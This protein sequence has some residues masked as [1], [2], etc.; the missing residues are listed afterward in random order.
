MVVKPAVDRRRLVLISLMW[1]GALAGSWAVYQARRPTK[2]PIAKPGRAAVSAAVVAGAAGAVDQIPTHFR[3]NP[4]HTAQSPYVGPAL[5][6]VRWKRDLG[7]RITAQPVIG[8]DANI[9]I[10]THDGVLWTLNSEGIVVRKRNLGARIF[11]AALVA[12]DGTLYVGTDGRGFFGLDARSNTRF[13]L[14]NG[15]LAGADADT[16]PTLARDGS[17]R[18]AAGD[19][20]YSINRDGEVLWT[21]RADDKIFTSPTLDDNG[22][23]YI[24][25]QDEHVYAVDSDGKLLFRFRTG[26]DIDA[27]PVLGEDGTIYVG[28][29]DQNVYAISQA[30]VQRW[31]TKLDGY[32]RGALALG[33][34]ASLLATHW[35]QNSALIALDRETGEKRFRF[36][37]S[38]TDRPDTGVRGGA[39]V[40]ATGAIYVGSD[41]DY[42][43]ALTPEGKLRWALAMGSDA[44]ASTTLAADG[45]LYAAS[46]K[47]VLYAIGG[48]E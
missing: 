39:L 23:A 16:A 26:G 28:S 45:T 32:V 31:K 4:R 36:A 12:A 43:Y 40:D 17:I 11:A 47:G 22:T 21:F 48:N 24:G 13:Q 6:A 10:G 27:S 15:T 14:Q 3:I 9:H 29:D 33:S 34:G 46:A 42:L 37:F 25:A 44:E 41:D 2:P 20:L 19:R 7:A 5:G 18:F 30:G 1:I 8:P 38:I 35:G